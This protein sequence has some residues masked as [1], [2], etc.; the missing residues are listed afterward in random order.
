[1]IRDFTAGLATFALSLGMSILMPAHSSH[2]LASGLPP[3]QQGLVDSQV[4]SHAA[5]ERADEAAAEQATAAAAAPPQP[6]SVQ[7]VIRG[8]FQP[9]GDQAVGWAEQIAF[10]ESTYDPHAVNT[11]S[12]AEGLFQFLPSTWAGTPFASQ[13][14]FDPVANAR[15]AAWLLQTYGPSQWECQAS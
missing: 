7:D 14:P 3:L 5:S 10:C 4:S 1:M 13:S 12:G 8:A 2:P 11:D 15:A 6:P 9:M